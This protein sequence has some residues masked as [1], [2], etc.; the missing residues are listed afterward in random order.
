MPSQE[1]RQDTYRRNCSVPASTSTSTSS[2]VSQP[3]GNQAAQEQMK[4]KVQGEPVDV[5]AYD[6]TG[7]ITISIGHTFMLGGDAPFSSFEGMVDSILAQAGSRPIGTLKI[8]THASPGQLLLGQGQDMLVLGTFSLQELL[9]SFSRLAGHFAPNGQ[10]LIHGCN[11]AQYENGEYFLSQ[12]SQIWGVPV[13]AGRE[14]QHALVPGLDG[15]T[16]TASPDG[17]GGTFLTEDRG[18]L[19]D[20]GLR[21]AG[22]VADLVT[23]G[24]SE[25]GDI[26]DWVFGE[27]K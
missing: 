20:V 4:A 25:V 2:S 9:P 23:K 7:G 3:Y 18:P 21:V 11:F 10:V 22:G 26:W 19:A 8:L 13:S 1:Q 27:D 16:V 17:Q 24:T 14:T 5:V 15:T 12:L 6:E